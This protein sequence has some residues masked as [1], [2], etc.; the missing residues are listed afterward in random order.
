MLS[1]N[2]VHNVNTLDIA[3]LNCFAIELFQWSQP[4]QVTLT[5]N[6]DFC[7]NR[8][9]VQNLEQGGLKAKLQRPCR[10][11]TVENNPNSFID[12][13]LNTKSLTL[14]C[15]VNSIEICRYSAKQ[16]KFEKISLL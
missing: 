1:E 12:I 13:P 3:N 9:V 7:G 2:Y 4:L 15:I 11:R 10:F 16:R 6:T 5:H 14:V 8:A